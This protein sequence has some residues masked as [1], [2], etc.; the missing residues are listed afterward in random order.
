[1]Y[2]YCHHDSNHGLWSQCFL[3][4]PEQNASNQES[5]HY[6]RWFCLAKPMKLTWLK[7]FHLI[8][9]N[10]YGISSVLRQNILTTLWCCRSG[11]AKVEQ[12]LHCR[13][14]EILWDGGWNIFDQVC[15]I[16]F[17]KQNQ[18]I[19]TFVM[20]KWTTLMNLCKNMRVYIQHYSKQY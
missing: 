11:V 20:Q 9:E 13:T 6:K 7:T 16:G 1:M 8:L 15:F 4:G 17:V 5:L 18:I 14:E 10:F 2:R 12:I 3:N 19:F